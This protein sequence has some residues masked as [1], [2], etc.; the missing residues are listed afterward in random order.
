MGTVTNLLL[1]SLAVVIAQAEV[2]LEDDRPYLSVQDGHRAVLECCYTAKEKSEKFVW[3]RFVHENNTVKGP[4]PVNDSLVSPEEKGSKLFCGIIDYPSVQLKD[5]GFYQCWLNKSKVFT[6][7][8][9]LH[10][11]KPLEKTLDLKE[12]TKNKI[13]TAEGVMLFVVVVIP[14]ATLLL[15]SRKLSELEKKKVRKEEE[16]IYQGLNLDDCS[17]T[18]D[19]IERSQ[20]HDPYEDVCILE[21]EEEEIQLEKP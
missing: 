1:C 4:L 7:G 11:F 21:E 16:N 17:T 14:A 15:Q 3:Y 12:S 19:Q 2:F 18:Y 6:H 5:S 10:V 13:L 8:T 9:Y 20:A